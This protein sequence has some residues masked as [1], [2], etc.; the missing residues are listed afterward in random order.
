MSI[1][2]AS[3]LIFQTNDR[4]LFTSIN[5]RL[6]TSLIADVVQWVGVELKPQT[7]KLSI[8]D[9][10]LIVIALLHELVATASCMFPPAS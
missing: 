1:S 9:E 7:A 6:L 2:F 5:I 10:G 3:H 4:G 8:A